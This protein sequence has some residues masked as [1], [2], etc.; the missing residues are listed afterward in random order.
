M[1]PWLSEKT[2][3]FFSFTRAGSALALDFNRRNRLIRLSR[4]THRIHQNR[5]SL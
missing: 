1:M 2:L 3:I 4:Q 5:F